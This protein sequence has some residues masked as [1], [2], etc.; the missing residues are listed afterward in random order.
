MKI[1]RS[2]WIRGLVLVALGAL[3]LMRLLHWRLSSGK[4]GIDVLILCLS[5]APFLVA[6]LAVAAPMSARLKRYQALFILAVYP[7]T[8]LPAALNDWVRHKDLSSAEEHGVILAVCTC[9]LFVALVP[10]CIETL[11]KRVKLV[12]TAQL[13]G[14]VTDGVSVLQGVS[15][16]ECS[17]DW[18]QRLSKT[19]T[20][21]EGA[22]GLPTVSEGPIH[23]LRFTWEGATTL[24]F[25][26]QLSPD[27]PPLAVRMKLRPVLVS[28][29]TRSEN[30]STEAASPQKTG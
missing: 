8:W 29:Y 23:Y 1:T 24:R 10:L 21:Y 15:V 25:A 3:A 16:E 19:K 9:I 7:A 2:D 30:A 27:A 13:R 6:G 14:I 20:D 17:A 22:F 26:V 28:T 4:P 5:L 18:K 12:I 11:R